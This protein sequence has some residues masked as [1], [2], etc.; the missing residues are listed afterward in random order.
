VHQLVQMQHQQMYFHCVV[1]MQIKVKLNLEQRIELKKKQTWQSDTNNLLKLPDVSPISSFSKSFPNTIK[2]MIIQLLNKY[3]LSILNIL[4]ETK[5][6]LHLW[7]AIFM[8]LI[9]ALEAV[10]MT[11]IIVSSLVPIPSIAL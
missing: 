5:L 1:P 11:S 10:H 6:N 3:N 8:L 2:N 9:S 7:Y 4:I